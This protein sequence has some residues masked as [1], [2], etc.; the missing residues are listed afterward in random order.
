[1]IIF[2]AVPIFLFGLLLIPIVIF[3]YFFRGKIKKIK[4]PSLLFWEPLKRIETKGHF[5]DKLPFPLTLL[6][7][8]LIIIFLT[9]AAASPRVPIK[10]KAPPLVFILDNSYSMLAGGKEQGIKTI[11]DEVEKFP[12]SKCYFIIAGSKIMTPANEGIKNH[13][14]ISDIIKKWKCLD[15]N[16][17][18]QSA[19]QFSKKILPSNSII[20]IISDHI[21]ENITESNNLKYKALG[22]PTPNIA[23]VNAARN[24]NATEEHLYFEIANFSDTTNNI[25]LNIKYK[26][27]PQKI[28]KKISCPPNSTKK[29]ILKLPISN[30]IIIAEIL[31][32]S[33]KFDNTVVLLPEK[34]YK[35]NIKLSFKNKTLLKSLKKAI[36]DDLVSISPSNGASEFLF[37]DYISTPSNPEQWLLF[38]HVIPKKMTSFFISPFIIDR[39][40]AVNESVFPDGVIW[41]A[42][43]NQFMPGIPLIS[44]GNTSLLTEQLSEFTNKIYHLQINPAKT[45]LFRSPAWPLLIWNMINLRII[46]LPGPEEDNYRLGDLVNIHIPYNTHSINI[47]SPDKKKSSYNPST[48]VFS[49]LANQA[50]IWTIETPKQ[51]WLFAVNT[52][53]FKE[54]NMMYL[55]TQTLN[56]ISNINIFYNSFYDF[57][58]IL[59]IAALIS[60]MI[61]QF[62]FTRRKQ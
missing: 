60:L 56:N 19:L 27:S 37:S 50:G 30:D 26:N 48:R 52:L 9:L 3:I 32:S 40:N 15:P 4:V 18:I 36:P 38:F 34:N 25:S 13:K 5:F 42:S 8:I 28:I 29:I 46:N 53:N 58:W 12:Y 24:T 22:T 51:K 16:S 10:E 17:D 62:I 11:Y 43:N 41:S 45:S 20:V 23:I 39:D 7:E 59:C 61:H 35:I 57:S 14:E 1:M 55:K 54:S 6:F 49:I 21:A 44:A 47:I 31:D 2:F 33:I